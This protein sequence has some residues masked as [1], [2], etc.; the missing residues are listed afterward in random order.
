MFPLLNDVCARVNNEAHKNLFTEHFDGLLMHF[1]H[2][3]KDLDFTKFAWIQNPFV[4]EQY[5]EFGLTTIEKET[6]IELS[7]D[8]SLKQKFQSEPLVQFWLDR[9]EEYNTLSSKALQ[10]LLPE[11]AIC[12]IGFM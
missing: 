2:Y 10:V 3:F 4:D 11:S 6:L 5:D 9:S 12:N 8:T 1:S 7:F